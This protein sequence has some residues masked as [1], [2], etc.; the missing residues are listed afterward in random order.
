[1]T[2]LDLFCTPSAQKNVEV[3]RFSFSNRG[4]IKLIAGPC[5]LE[6]RDLAM[7][8]AEH[9]A[10][11]SDRLSI[12][13]VFKGSFDKANRTSLSGRGMG[14]DQA[15]KI[16]QE[17]K[18][19]FG[20]PVLTDVH[21]P[22]QCKDVAEVVDILQIPAFLCRQTDLI[23]SAAST[24]R[25]LHIKKGQFLSPQEM[26]KVAEKAAASGA[27]GVLLCERG[28]S[29]GYNM[30]INDMRSLPIMAASGWP[31]IFDATHSVQR[32]GALGGVSGGDRCMVEAL[33]RAALG[34]GVS[35]LF[36]ETHPCPQEALS[37][38]PNMVPLDQIEGLLKT[39][40]AIDQCTKNHV[41]Q[42]FSLS[43]F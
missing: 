39:C 15:M 7:R 35:G 3:G 31:V 12:P 27:S 11:V 21:L 8:V 34:V 25:P 24:G 29:F 42:E 36:M 41:Y 16:F 6:S 2:N 5:S 23:Q 18:R 32:P 30:L 1:V 10:G 33:A 9:L 17:I 20:C 14:W 22:H 40:I 19:S 38:G 28:F 4:K 37:D 13:F 26:H 43:S